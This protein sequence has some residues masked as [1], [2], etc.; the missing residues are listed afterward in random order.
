MS[1][2]KSPNMMHWIVSALLMMAQGCHH[3]QH[4]PPPVVAPEAARELNKAILPE[5]VIEPPDLLSI[6]AINIVPKAP[7]QLRP[8]DTVQITVDGT[9][10][11][12]PIAGDFPIQLDGTIDL[13]TIY[14]TVSVKGQ[15][16]QEAKQSI[17]TQLRSTLRQPKVRLTLVDIA[18]RQQIA[19]EHLV[20][21]DGKVT[22]G[23]YGKV[24]V[25]GMTVPDAKLAIERHLSQYLESPEVAVDVFGYNSKFYYVITQGAAVG[26]GVY[27][28]SNTGN[29]TV[30]DAISQINGLQPEASL[31]IWVAR[32]T[33]ESGTHQVMPV[34][35]YGVTQLGDTETN[36]QVLPGD[37]VYIAADKLIR[38]DTRL[39][40][41]T[42]PLE[43]LFGFTLLG[44][45]TVTRLSGKVLQGGGNPRGGGTN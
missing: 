26:D 11:E 34:D 38:F 21:P 42:A 16:P 17:E 10:P 40:L 45:G 13:G 29:E 37:R 30:L 41:M 7:Y 4:A 22:L 6:E 3:L 1:T 14:G 28:F 5:Y 8:G 39:A 24:S 9:L 18:G 44:T 27:R 33:P 25:I 32:P 35:W 23:T 19:G 43:R 31:N 20:G 2:R 12:A 36:Y 15:T